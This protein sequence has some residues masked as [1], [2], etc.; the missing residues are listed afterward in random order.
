M[1]SHLQLNKRYKDIEEHD[2]S[3]SIK[4]LDQTIDIGVKTIEVL[5]T[6]GEQINNV[7][8]LLDGINV[9]VQSANKTM[10]KINSFG[11]NFTKIFR[12]S[13]WKNKKYVESQ[14]ISEVIPEN[15]HQINNINEKINDT[16]LIEREQDN[17]DINKLSS[18]LDI[19][20]DIA[21]LQGVQLNEHNKLLD[22][23]NPKMDRSNQQITTLNRNIIR[24][25]D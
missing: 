12:P 11:Y 4:I 6:Q 5:E 19:L 18:R 9:N 8:K 24:K 15:T 25:L 17:D 13:Y 16:L 2:F 7:N 1:D 3:E 10:A 14:I 22:Q 20:K 21:I 23:I